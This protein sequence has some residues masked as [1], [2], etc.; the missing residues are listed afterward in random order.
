LPRTVKNKVAYRISI[1]RRETFGL[2]SMVFGHLVSCSVPCQKDKKVVRNFV[3]TDTLQTKNHPKHCIVYMSS[4]IYFQLSS[5]FSKG[6]AAFLVSSQRTVCAP[7]HVTIETC[8]VETRND[9]YEKIRC[10]I[11]GMS[12]LMIRSDDAIYIVP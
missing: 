5:A 4:N 12:H 10:L 2:F 7:G 11:S 3:V 8:L 1:L 6:T 9:L